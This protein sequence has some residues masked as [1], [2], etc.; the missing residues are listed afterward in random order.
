MTTLRSGL[1]SALA[2]SAFTVASWAAEPP[3]KVKN[4]MP[5]FWA[6]QDEVPTLERA[7]RILRRFRD[8]VIEPNRDIYSK[9]EFKDATTDE[10]LLTYLQGLGPDLPA[11]RTLSDGLEARTRQVLERFKRQFPRFDGKLTI[12]FLPTF[13]RFDGRFTRLL[14]EPVVLLGPDAIARS[15]N[16]SADFEVVLAH[17][18]FHAHHARMNS[19]LYRDE[20]MPLY[21]RIWIE[22]L[23]TY[24]SEQ[25]NPQATSA[26][27]I[28]D[29]ATPADRGPMGPMADMVRNSFDS[30]DP[31]E[32]SKF[33]TYTAATGVPGRAG[34]VVGYEVAKGLAAKY[35]LND[36]TGLRGGK[37]RTLMRRQLDE[38][39][40]RTAM[41]QRGSGPKPE[42]LAGGPRR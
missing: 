27:L 10:A 24:A 11:M 4:L 7:D 2:L 16:D 14:E 26:Q 34:H 37:L 3:T 5:E 6:F 20:A 39:S 12:V 23:A 42:P 31:N 38:M 33:L 36:L 21:A 15:R 29:A 19:S 41:A 35:S 28:G 32:Q 18:I 1:L 22:G 8:G 25:V 30:M 40:V 17:E 9:A 13:N